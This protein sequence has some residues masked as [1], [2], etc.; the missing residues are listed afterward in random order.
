MKLKQVASVGAGYPFRGKIPDVPSSG[1]VAVQ[2]KDVLLQQEIQWVE[3]IETEL[4]GKRDPGWLQ[5]GDILFAARGSH[6]YAVLVTN[7]ISKAGIK[8]VAAPHFYVVSVKQEE[9]LPE[10]LVWL[11]NQ[12]PCKRYFEQNAEGSLTKSIRRSVLEEA[13]IAIPPLYRQ[14]AIVG[15]VKTMRKEQEIVE[16]YVRNSEQLLNAIS[17]NLMNEFNT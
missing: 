2:M 16:M 4:G 7:E 13:P 8:A 9:V 6:N 12:R 14:K 17:T 1:V 3:C 11:L 5:Q 15:L 10:Y